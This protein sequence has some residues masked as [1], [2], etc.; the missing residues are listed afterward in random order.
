MPDESSNIT[1]VYSGEYG[2]PFL[3]FKTGATDEMAGC[4][5]IQ[6]LNHCLYQ[7]ININ[8]PLPNPPPA[9]RADADVQATFNA[10]AQVHKAACEKG[11]GKIKKYLAQ[12]VKTKA[13][14]ANATCLPLL[15]K[16]LMA[17]YDPE[18]FLARMLMI[19]ELVT[20]EKGE[21]TFEEFAN[22]KKYLGQRVGAIAEAEGT[23]AGLVNGVRDEQDLRDRMEE[24][25][26]ED[27]NAQNNDLID[28]IVRELTQ[29]ER[30]EKAREA[31]ED[32]EAK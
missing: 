30:T 28:R 2:E 20:A 31:R 22:R 10:M 5:A 21:K 14:I 15:W 7:G 27:P 11:F 9:M 29:R 23:L 4:G 19:I 1:S 8:D 17:T 13:E 3:E 24:I 32:A 12:V 26:N 6:G 16:R 25:I 18:I